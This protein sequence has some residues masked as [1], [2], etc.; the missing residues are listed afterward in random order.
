MANRDLDQ[1][2]A[3]QLALVPISGSFVIDGASAVSSQNPTGTNVLTV[4]KPAG[5]GI[6]QVLL[7]DVWPDILWAD[8][9]LLIP[10]G[11]LDRDI[12]P[13]VVTPSTGVVQ[14]QVR[15]SSDGTAVDPV[16]MT[17]MFNIMCKNS[18]VTP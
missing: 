5:T 1:V 17:V 6:Y 2:N 16:S 10:A 7:A 11:T 12:K 3:V 9:T 13:I 18:S 15:K 4:S 14:F 8:A